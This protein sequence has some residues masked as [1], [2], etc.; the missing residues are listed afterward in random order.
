AGLSGR[1]PYA[2]AERT[3]LERRERGL[4]A[5]MGFTMRRPD[6]SCHPELLLRDARSV[7]A[8]AHSYARPE[9]AKPGEEPR[10]GPPRST[11][12]DEY[13]VL[14]DRL[15]ALGEHLREL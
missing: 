12:R 5:D 15:R 8:A 3:I 14:R 7:V 4:F 11:R 9:P 13:A 6:R 1:E 2:R 10:G